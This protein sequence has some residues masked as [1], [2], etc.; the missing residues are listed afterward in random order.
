MP[1]KVQGCGR[2]PHLAVLLLLAGCAI[3]GMPLSSDA[4][5]KIKAVRIVAMEPLDQTFGGDAKPFKEIVAAE[6]RILVKE[7]LTQLGLLE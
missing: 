4:V 1:A 3:S 2:I 5:K 7:C 6:G